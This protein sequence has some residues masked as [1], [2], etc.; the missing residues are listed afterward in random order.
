[1]WESTSYMLSR[2]PAHLFGHDLLMD[3]RLD[4]KNMG[5]TN[6]ESKL[7]VLNDVLDKYS[8]YVV[9][10]LIVKPNTKPQFFRARQVSDTLKDAVDKQ[11]KRQEAH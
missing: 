2:G 8:V 4:W 9:F 10:K 5:V 1:M 6:I 3:I 7:L 11:L